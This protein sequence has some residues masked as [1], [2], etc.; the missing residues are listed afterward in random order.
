MVTFYS[1]SASFTIYVYTND[2]RNLLYS[3]K[4]NTKKRILSHLFV[5]NIL[6]S[7]SPHLDLIPN[8]VEYLS[9]KCFQR[10]KSL[11]FYK[12][13]EFW[14]QSL[15][16]WLKISSFQLNV[17]QLIRNGECSN[18]WCTWS[19]LYPFSVVILSWLITRITM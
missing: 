1:W 17:K 4:A 10:K 6:H 18:W 14:Y 16:K 15:A 7:L 8:F 11:I 2:N 9:Q 13:C 12:V 3:P 5:S 19:T